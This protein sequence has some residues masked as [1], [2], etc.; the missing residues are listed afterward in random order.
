MT[1][2]PTVR[3]NQ[4]TSTSPGLVA[5]VAGGEPTP[6]S[7]ETFQNMVA[8]YNPDDAETWIPQ[9]PTPDTMPHSTL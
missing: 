7:E 5:S 8:P 3:V 9:T 2:P 6:M 4:E 1:P